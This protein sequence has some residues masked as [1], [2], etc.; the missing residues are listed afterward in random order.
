MMSQLEEVRL[1]KSI[2]FKKKVER[3]ELL[4]KNNLVEFYGR[5][6]VN[7]TAVCN[8]A[9]IA[10]PKFVNKNKTYNFWSKGQLVKRRVR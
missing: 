10:L 6:S 7:E 3:E 8:L 5:E 4:E 1:A 9:S 2:E